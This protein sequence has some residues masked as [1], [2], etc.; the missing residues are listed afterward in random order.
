MIDFQQYPF[1][2]FVVVFYSKAL[3]LPFFVQRSVCA[4]RFQRAGIPLD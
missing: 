3:T 2:N 1:Q 4:R